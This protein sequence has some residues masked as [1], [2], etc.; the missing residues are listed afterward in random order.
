MIN[1]LSKKSKSKKIAKDF[2]LKK[3]FNSA[4]HK[5]MVIHA[6]RK[7]SEDQK[8]LIKKYDRQFSN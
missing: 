8:K 7:S 1:L 3:M 4:D 5:K 2:I 6:A